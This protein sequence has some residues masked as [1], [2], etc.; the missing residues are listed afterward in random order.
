MTDSGRSA[1]LAVSPPAG[2]GSNPRRQVEAVQRRRPNPH[3]NLTGPGAR[4]VDIGHLGSLI[5]TSERENLHCSLSS[6]L[7][8]RMLHFHPT[9]QPERLLQLADATHDRRCVTGHNRV[10][11]SMLP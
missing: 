2:T 4:Q 6:S 3:P 10:E 7:V 5:E 8:E 1:S 9:R 11:D